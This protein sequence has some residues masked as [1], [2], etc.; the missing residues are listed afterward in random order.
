M[1]NIFK[2]HNVV[3]DEELDKLEKG[4][5]LKH[6]RLE[7]TVEMMHQKADQEINE[8]EEELYEYRKLELSGM[9]KTNYHLNN[10]FESIS[11]K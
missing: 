4:T 10:Y 1:A 8:G 3:R 5:A 6:Q 9:M 7:E 2:M 11:Q